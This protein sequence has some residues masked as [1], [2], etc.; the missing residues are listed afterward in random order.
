MW[1]KFSWNYPEDHQATTR[2]NGHLKA[3]DLMTAQ[4]IDKYPS[5]P[6]ISSKSATRPM[7]IGMEGARAPYGLYTNVR[8]VS[9][10]Y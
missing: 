10:S 2:A 5:C 3:A 6:S 8:T 7:D 4:Q 1:G 9:C